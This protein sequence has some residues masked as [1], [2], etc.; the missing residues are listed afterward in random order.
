M[1]NSIHAVVLSGGVGS[2][3]WPAS[4]EKDPKQF[5]K[6]TDGLS[7]LQKAFLRCADIPHTSS[8]LSVTNRDFLFRIKDEFNQLVDSNENLN[9]IRQSYILEPFGRNTAAA[10]ISAAIQIKSQYGEDAIMLVLPSDH[11]VSNKESFNIAVEQASKLAQEGQVVLFGIK[12]DSPQTGYGYIK[13]SQDSIAKFVEKPSLEKAQQYIDEGN[14]YWNSG[15]FCFTAKTIL[16]ECSLYCQD[17]LE[18]VEET[19]KKSEIF[20]GNI[21]SSLELNQESFENVRSDSI[22]YA[23]MEKS[24]KISLVTCD[25]GWSD[26]GN[27]NAISDLNS[28]KDENGNVLRGQAVLQ[29]TLNCYIE[30]KDRVIGA[31][32]LDNLLVIDTKDALLV[33]N[34]NKSQQVKDIYAKIKEQGSETYKNHLTVHR[35]WGTYTVLEE[36]LGFKI[37]RIEVNQSS[38][39]SLQ[40]HKHR[41]E[42]WVVVSGE[43]KVINGDQELILKEGNSTFIPA[44]HKHRLENL[45]KDKLVLIEVQVGNY[46]GEDDIIRFDDI[47][48]RLGRAHV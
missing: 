42:H 48:G 46:L 25:I 7:L 38:K 6:L 14:Y 22:D 24:Q 15:L 41:S 44:E 43:A 21:Y 12:P 26:V 29:D 18:Q 13:S 1:K 5:I 23:V 33:A 8:I 34:K 36:G 4:R 31:L 28:D 2:R 47:Y 11:I 16:D 19:V 27:W 32:G 45:G 10:I 37:K 20:Q 9:S 3:L 39:L 35:P 17:I 30:S 40:M